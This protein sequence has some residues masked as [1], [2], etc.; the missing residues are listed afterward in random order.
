M[1]MIKLDASNFETEALQSGVPVLV[2]FWA[3]WCAP[4]RMLSPLVDEIAGEMEGRMKVGKVNVDEESAIA[5]RYGVRSIPT[6]ILFKNGEVAATSIGVKPKEE[7]LK[8]LGT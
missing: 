6:L 7:I 2:D 3:E 4:C 1:V 5:V 8:M